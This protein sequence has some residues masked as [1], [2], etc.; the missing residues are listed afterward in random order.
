MK[1]EK[2][3]QERREEVII[4]EEEG[5]SLV[6]PSGSG[7]PVVG[8]RPR[9][10][11]KTKRPQ[12]VADPNRGSKVEKTKNRHDHS[13]SEAD[14]EGRTKVSFADSPSIKCYPR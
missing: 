9:M 8:D 12:N 2:S 7:K 14:Y 4:E 11:S 1:P 5:K 6:P 13:D 10:A 3:E